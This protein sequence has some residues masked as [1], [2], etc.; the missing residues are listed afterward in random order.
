MVVV[1]VTIAVA[2]ATVERQDCRQQRRA[3]MHQAA[4]RAI[5]DTEPGDEPGE[6]GVA[7]WHGATAAAAG[8]AQRRVLGVQRA[9]PT[10]VL[11][12][13]SDTKWSFEFTDFNSMG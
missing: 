8:A 5:K 12:I 2:V 6:A 9:N 13:T 1:V 3:S 10:K 4:A 11:V 7:K